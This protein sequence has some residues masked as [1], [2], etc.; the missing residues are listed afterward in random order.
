ME[1]FLEPLSE[2]GASLSCP[3]K[4]IRDM[5]AS[6][7]RTIFNN[8][9]NNSAGNWHEKSLNTTALKSLFDVCPNSPKN[10]PLPK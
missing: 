3:D 7:L 4:C 6:Q 1:L 8:E 9:V 2:T 10:Q 5:K